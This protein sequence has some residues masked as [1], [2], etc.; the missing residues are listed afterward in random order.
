MAELSAAD[1]PTGTIKLVLEWV[2]TDPIRASWALVAEVDGKRRKSLLAQLED[3]AA[4][5]IEPTP[6]ERK[7]ALADGL[8]DD[9]VRLRGQMFAPTIEKKAVKLAG[10][11]HSAD[12]VEIVEIERDEPTFTEKKLLAQTISI[13]L[14]KALE[15]GGNAATGEGGVLDEV[16]KARAARRE[17][18]AAAAA[19]ASGRR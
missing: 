4:T 5:P 6:A 2:G 14:D 18:A 15:L 8:L 9:A 19:A 13:V 12:Q 17:S 11:E 3:I 7:Q 10:G 1:V 16:S